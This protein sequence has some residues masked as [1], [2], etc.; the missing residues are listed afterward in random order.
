MFFQATLT[1]EK[2]FKD[3]NTT[4]LMAQKLSPVPTR[5]KWKPVWPR[6]GNLAAGALGGKILVTSARS[7]KIC[8][9]CKGREESSTRTQKS[10]E[11]LAVS[12]RGGKKRKLVPRTDWK[13]TVS[14]LY[15]KKKR[16]KTCL[17]L[18]AWPKITV[19]RAMQTLALRQNLAYT[20]SSIWTR[21][22][23]RQSLM[24]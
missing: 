8:N 14:L 12:E 22:R 9:R 4:W 1:K 13:E 18:L 16:F 24:N 6:A 17:S 7:G 5:E 20:R 3:H 2:Y 11:K 15:E 10:P 23:T 21:K 19:I